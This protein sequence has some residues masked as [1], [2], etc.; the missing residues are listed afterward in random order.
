MTTFAALWRK[1]QN[2][3]YRS[4]FVATQL[5][6]GVPFQIRALRRKRGWSQ[7]Q[8]AKAAGLSQGEISRAENLD[9][10]N[11]TFNTVLAIAEGLDVAFVG[12]FVPFG[13][14]ATWFDTLSEDAI[15]VPTFEEENLKRR[16]PAQFSTAGEAQCGSLDA[17][18]DNGSKISA[19]TDRALQDDGRLRQQE[20]APC[21]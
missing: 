3:K 20:Y 18:I 7:E 1:L 2:R 21:A 12:R 15:I 4:A 6:R 17:M 13:E 11:L 5:K 9:Y 10:G 8:L 16:R 14:V 19:P